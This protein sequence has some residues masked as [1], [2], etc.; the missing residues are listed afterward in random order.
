MTSDPDPDATAD[1]LSFKERVR[2]RAYSLWEQ[3]GRR[4]G[5]AEQYWLAAEAMEKQ[6]NLV[7]EEGEESFPASDPPSQTGFSG[8]KIDPLS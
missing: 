7:D 4:D 6:D 1:D 3:D 8:P 5:L 2:L